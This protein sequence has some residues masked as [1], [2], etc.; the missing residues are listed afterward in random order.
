MST[1]AATD[2]T[3]VYGTYTSWADPTGNV[4]DPAKE[5]GQKEFL[6]LLVTQM[7]HQ[8]PLNPSSDLDSIAQMA[9][10][11]SLEQ[12]RSMVED[13]RLLRNDQELLKANSLIGR[14]VEA[15]NADQ[16][17]TFG[18]VTAVQMEAGKPKV[19]VDGKSYDLDQLRTITMPQVAA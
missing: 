13:I 2:A 8:D 19:V 16:T 10:F 6:Q 3:K 5:L 14:T 17:H 12:T 18:T 11:T 7:S 1:T 15:V 9:S 4:R